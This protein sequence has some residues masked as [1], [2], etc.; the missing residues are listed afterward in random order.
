MKSGNQFLSLLLWGICAALLTC[1]NPSAVGDGSEIGNA[2]VL[3]SV[4]TPGGTPASGAEVFI[5]PID[6]LP[7]AMP[8]DGLLPDAVTNAD[9]LLSIERADTGR[10]FIEVRRENAYSLAVLCTLVLDSQQV[11]PSDTLRPPAVLTGAVFDESGT[12]VPSCAVQAY[13]LE[14][15][16]FTNQSGIFSLTLP[17]GKFSLMMRPVASELESRLLSGITVGAGEQRSLDTVVLIRGC[18]DFA[19]D[20]ARVRELLDSNGISTPVSLY[21]TT[22][23]KSG[24]IIRLELEKLNQSFTVLP[25]IKDLQKLQA[26]TIETGVNNSLILHENIALLSNLT[27]LHISGGMLD[28]F[29]TIPANMSNLVNLKITHNNLTS[30]PPWV[31]TLR[32]VQWLNLDGNAISAIPVEIG[33]MQSLSRLHVGGNMLSALPAELS[34]LTSLSRLSVEGNQL[35]SLPPGLMRNQNLTYVTVQDNRLCTLPPEMV[36]W[37]NS[38]A[39]ADWRETQVCP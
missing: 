32:N 33:D 31:D 17:R 35:S 34:N 26:L 25:S 1:S 37:L 9:G 28:S 24:R 39:E 3:C 8:T 30:I 12:A 27:Q 10:F 16:A 14:R 22:S 7:D 38:V 13:G 20:S 19:C 5:R 2:R 15:T 36:D 29:P 11:L 23:E 4:Y 21:S 6:Y 18:Q